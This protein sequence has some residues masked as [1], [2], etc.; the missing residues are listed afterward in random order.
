M[1]IHGDRNWGY[2]FY[3]VVDEDLVVRRLTC[4]GDCK[5]YGHAEKCSMLTIDSFE[6]GLAKMRPNRCSCLDRC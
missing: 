2:C 5:F 3:F 1:A 4:P 6:L